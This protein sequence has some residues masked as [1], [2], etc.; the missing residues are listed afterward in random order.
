LIGRHFFSLER[1]LSNLFFFS[2][3][4][5][6]LLSFFLLTIV[7]GGGL[8]LVFLDFFLLTNDVSFFYRGLNLGC[9]LGQLCC[10]QSQLSN[11][12]SQL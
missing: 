2:I 10:L 1:I 5:L 3:D 11:Y 4:L 7:C 12:L 8:G 6:L 9:K